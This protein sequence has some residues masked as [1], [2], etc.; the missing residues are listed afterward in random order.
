MKLLIL[1]FSAVLTWASWGQDT[2]LVFVDDF[3]TRGFI[4][5]ND[6]LDGKPLLEN[7]EEAVSDFR[8]SAA[9]NEASCVVPPHAVV[10]VKLAGS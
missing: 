1:L 9:G 7:K 8:V 4:I 10:F 3:E 6:K 5:T 2:N